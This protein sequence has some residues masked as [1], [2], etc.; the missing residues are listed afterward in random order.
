MA[1]YGKEKQGRKSEHTDQPKEMTRIYFEEKACR[2]GTRRFSV[3]L[4]R[5][6]FAD[7]ILNYPPAGAA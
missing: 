3:L 6:A 1:Y 4:P 5:R 7:L 2:F